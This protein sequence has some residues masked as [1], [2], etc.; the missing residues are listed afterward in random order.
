M[1]RPGAP[2]PRRFPGGVA[3][4]T[5]EDYRGRR[6]DHSLGGEQ[7]EGRRAVLE[8]LRAQRRRVREVL[9]AEGRDASEGLEE[10]A[11]LA[12]RQNVSLRYVAERHL[13]TIARTDA[14][15]GVV[16]RAEPLEEHRLETL[17]SSRDKAPVFLVVLEGVSDP[18]NLGAVVRTAECAGATGLV[19]P[20][21]RAAGI[22]PAATKAAAGAIEYLPIAPVA[23]IPTALAELS[24]L[25]IWTVG[26]DQEGTQPLFGLDLADQPIALVLG[27]E[28]RGLSA[29]TRRRCDVLVRIPLG[30]A[31]AALNVSAA[32]AIACFEIARRRASPGGETSASRS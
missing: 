21:H 32:A 6:N 24:R 10:I 13:A 7:I 17:A 27:A 19:L 8:L 11:S 20:R 5:R 15:Q 9:V 26:L 16:A 22:T 28:G 29:L 18:H 30:G 14:P 31:I 2:G 1:T 12:R 23:G 4:G 25:G 3:R